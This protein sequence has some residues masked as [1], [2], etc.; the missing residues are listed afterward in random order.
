MTKP[1]SRL[2]TLILLLQRQPN[3]K[4]ADLANSLGVSFRRLHY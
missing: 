3:Q 4:A 1:A 2:D